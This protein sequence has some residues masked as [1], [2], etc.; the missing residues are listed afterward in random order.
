MVDHS[1]CYNVVVVGAGHAGCEAALA[2]ARMGTR[3]LMVTLRKDTIA[4]MSCNPAIGGL[5]KGHL[6]REIDALGGEMGKV[7]D[8]T[9]IQF[10]RLNMKKGPA[11]RASR[12]QADKYRYSLDM[13]RVLEEQ[14][15]LD[16]HEGLVDSLLFEG[17]RVRGVVTHT[18]QIYRAE[19]VILAA[20]T[21]LKGVIHIGDESHSAGR[22]GEC[23]A[24]KLSESLFDLGFEVARLKTGTPPRLHADSIDFS[25]MQ[26]QYGDP[27]PTPFSF[28]NER[29][30]QEQIPCH[31]TYTNERTHS[32]IRDNLLKSA[33]YS[34]RI[35]GTG[36]R[37][38]PSVE[39]KVVRFP[40]KER[41]QLFVEPEGLDTPEIY[42][43]GL[44]M[45][46]PE[47][48][49]LDV[50]HSIEGLE[51]ARVL[52]SA[53]AVEYDYMP[54]TQLWPTLETKLVEGLYFAGQ[55]NGTSGYEEA[56]AQGLM[57]GV[58]ATLKLQGRPPLILD[59]SQAYIGVLI[60]DLVTEEIRE[61][62]RMFTSRAEYRLELREDNADLR[63]TPIG[64][65]LG[66]IGSE[67]FGRFCQKRKQ[68]DN[69]MARLAREQ[70][71]PNQVTQAQLRACGT[72]EL[73]KPL[74]LAKLLSRPELGYGVID[75]LSPPA[76]PLGRAV[77]EQIELSVKYEG[78][79][80]RQDSQ[81][82]QFRR[83]EHMRLPQDLDYASIKELRLEAREKLAQIQPVSLGQAS[84]IGGVSPADISVLMILLERRRRTENNEE[85]SAD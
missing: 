9:G 25:K 54:A 42:V 3:T 51:K 2:A 78:Y 11:V 16:I 14:T 72:S 49:Q 83:L 21:F 12:A 29:I 26:P 60:D 84:R 44:S 4:K 19:V 15:G 33:M 57:A 30:I 6:V 28:A 74:S 37:Y 64:H 82:E 61:P 55:I 32:L 75:T 13:A 73:N 24:D 46:L 52:R 69:E 77:R 48:I 79:I 23:A 36:P 45:S 10:R 58:N 76:E 5:A 50:V 41:H 59:R 39:V 7:I 35:V 17:R 22:V 66:L 8:R 62:Y 43:N 31:I 56:A 1:R 34:G 85:K 53:Y 63:L 70:V 67:R 27:E 18:G 65:E 20:G 68:I 47:E 38:C 40:D 81:I 80:R 71:V